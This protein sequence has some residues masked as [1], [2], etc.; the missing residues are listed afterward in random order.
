M[1]RHVVLFRWADGTT[2][3]A[4]EAVAAALAGLPG[5][6]PA[7]R[8]Y[9]FGSD[10]GLADG[11]YDFAVTADFDDEADYVT[12]R[13]HPMHRAAITEHIAPIVAERVAVQL[14]LDD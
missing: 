12:Y 3:A 5:Q 6:I 14:R 9:R 1:I 13:D 11:N 10:A 7:I 8:D 4:K 2:E